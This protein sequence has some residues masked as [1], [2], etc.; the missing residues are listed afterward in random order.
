MFFQRGLNVVHGEHGGTSEDARLVVF[1]QRL[2]AGKKEIAA[3]RIDGGERHAG[4]VHD[5]G[6]RHAGTACGGAGTG[7]SAAP[8]VA[9]ASARTLK[10]DAEFTLEVGV[11]VHDGGMDFHKFHGL[12][13]IL[14][15][16]CIIGHTVG[17]VADEHGVDAGIGNDADAAGVYRRG[18]RL[19]LGRSIVFHAAQSGKSLAAEFFHRDSFLRDAR[20]GHGRTHDHGPQN[21]CDAG[22]GHGFVHAADGD[23]LGPGVLE[24]KD[25]H[26]DLLR[27][28]GLEGSHGAADLIQ[29]FR[30]SGYGNDVSCRSQRR[31]K[32]C[33]EHGGLAERIVELPCRAGTGRNENALIFPGVVE[34]ERLS[35]RIPVHIEGVL[36]AFKKGKRIHVLE[37][38]ADLALD[39]GRK[40]RRIAFSS[41]E[42]HEHR[43]KFLTV[44]I[45]GEGNAERGCGLGT[46]TEK[47]E[48][49]QKEQK[50]GS[51]PFDR[52]A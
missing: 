17:R 21:G 45:V 40:R 24:R 11:D 52:S 5:T 47:H 27:L 49:T 6:G 18:G 16:L 32:L 35:Q 44:G 48:E 8:A 33:R 9:A 25:P 43:F 20:A 1:F 26:D 42:V 4:A 12:V 28:R 3:V 15:D 31:R 38:A 10:G 34:M 41:G 51:E 46:G 22:H 36:H 2:D 7:A 37:S 50:C 23:V 39:L 13:E 19:S 14:Y 30:R 29:V